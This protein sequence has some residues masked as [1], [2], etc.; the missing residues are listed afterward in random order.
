MPGWL[1]KLLGGGAGKLVDSVGSV[2]DNLIT[3]KEELAAAKLEV[4]KEVNRHME[5]V[6]ADATKQVELE[7]QDRTSARLREADFVKATGHIDYLQ[8][9]LAIAATGL[10]AYSL[11]AVIHGL[12][13]KEYENLV[14]NL[15]G[16]IE[17]LCVNVYNYY[18]GSSAG[19]R[20]K[21]M[22]GKS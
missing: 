18:F 14:H 12:V 10:F 15:L 21:D 17:G 16:I 9:V 8:W 19:S 3:N 7:I 11:Y 22:K 2:L 20:I 5:A 4:E 1:G 6:Q 13:S